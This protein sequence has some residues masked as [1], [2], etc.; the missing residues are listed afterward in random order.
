MTTLLTYD[1]VCVCVYL[2][3]FGISM[4]E[5]L[6]YWAMKDENVKLF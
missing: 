3:H 1:S 2:V 4:I 5:A 6:T